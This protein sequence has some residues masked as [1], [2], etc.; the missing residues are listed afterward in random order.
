MKTLYTSVLKALV[1]DKKIT[2]TQSDKVLVVV[3]KTMPTDDKKQG[4]E[5]PTD[6]QKP[7]GTPPTDN[8]KS[9]GTAQ[10]DG[11]K[12]RGTAN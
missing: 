11:E 1:T 4:G 10:K 5:A 8:Q 6:G 2:Q 12:P 9:S 3:V 7:S